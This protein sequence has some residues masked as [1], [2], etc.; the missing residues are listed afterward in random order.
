MNEIHFRENSENQLQITISFSFH[1]YNIFSD[2]TSS[3]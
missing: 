1:R 2:T 3:N